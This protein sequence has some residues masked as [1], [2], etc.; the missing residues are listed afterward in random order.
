MN[1]NNFLN[2]LDKN[3]LIK[4][5]E[6][7]TEELVKAGKEIAKMKEELADY[8]KAFALACKSG[9]YE[10]KTKIQDYFLKKV[11]KEK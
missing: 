4:R 5:K 2:Q 7:M 6:E 1:N 9:F 10:P 8:K 11:R 3:R